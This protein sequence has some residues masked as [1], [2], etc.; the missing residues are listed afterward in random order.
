LHGVIVAQSE[1]LG[2]GRGHSRLRL[3]VQRMPVVMDWLCLNSG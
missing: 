3:T 1:Q 2:A